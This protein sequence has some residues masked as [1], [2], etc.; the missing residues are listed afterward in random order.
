MI[1]SDTN[2]SGSMND[3]GLLMQL[4]AST[5]FF[6]NCEQFFFSLCAVDSY[7]DAERVYTNTGLQIEIDAHK[8]NT[9]LHVCRSEQHPSVCMFLSYSC[10]RITTYSKFTVSAPTTCYYCFCCCDS[11]KKKRYFLNCDRCNHTSNIAN[12]TRH[13]YATV[14]D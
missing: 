2:Y 12:L 13:C 8:H 3:S 14:H 1:A 6:S 9:A 7:Q 11:C 10:V 4:Y 5:I